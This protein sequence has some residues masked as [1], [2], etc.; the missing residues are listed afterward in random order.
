MINLFMLAPRVG[1]RGR[2]VPQSRTNEDAASV[3]FSQQPQ[4]SLIQ[5]LF[6]LRRIG[7]DANRAT[8]N[9]PARAPKCNQIASPGMDQKISE[10]DTRF[11]TRMISVRNRPCMRAP[12]RARP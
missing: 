6:G 12:E 9:H 1:P 4:N 2:F 10:I 5:A 7:C 8:E 11:S 3:S